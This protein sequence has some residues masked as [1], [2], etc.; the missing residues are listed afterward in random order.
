[1]KAMHDA[2][3]AGP[4]ALQV[5]CPGGWQA[6]P[7]CL[8]EAARLAPGLAWSAVDADRLTAGHWLSGADLQHPG[9]VP[10]PAARAALPA[11]DRV[12]L[13]Q[14]ERNIIAATGKASDGIVSRWINRPVSQAMSAVLLRWSGVRPGHAT[15]AAAL[16]GLA[17]I[18]ALLF[19]GGTGL[20]AGAVLFQLASIIDGVDGEIARATHRSSARGAMLDSVTD[21]LTNLGFIG[22]VSWNVYAHGGVEAGLAGACGFAFLALGS[23]LLGV[24]SRKDG[25]PFTFDALKHRF[26][27]R[28]TRLKQWLTYLTM[29]DFY[30][31]AAC[32]AILA[33]GAE[34]ALFAFAL[35]AAGWF[36]VLCWALYGPARGMR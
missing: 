33:G 5:A 3:L 8:A 24:Q 10:A 31:L 20:I 16:T 14:A 35:A 9:S 6:D 27:A 2:G 4:G 30:A 17:M 13:R 36:T 15:F 23:A 19:G 34:F 26:R 11:A 32:L 28:P 21:A 12:A 25:G 18:A 1:L 29:R 22:G 7:L